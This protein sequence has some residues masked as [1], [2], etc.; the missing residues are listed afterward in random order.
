MPP[1][2]GAV[3]KF[4]GVSI[5]DNLNLTRSG[6]DQNV[7]P[8][9][10]ATWAAWGQAQSDRLK[11]WGF[12]AAGMYSY[13]Y[14]DN[15]PSDGV[16]SEVTFQVSGQAARDDGTFYHCKSVNYNYGT[17]ACGSNFYMPSGGGSTDV[18]DVSCDNGGGYAGAVMSDLGSSGASSIYCPNCGLPAFSAM[19]LV[20]T[21]EAD[22]LYG[23][24]SLGHEDLG[25]IVAAH[26]PMMTASPS[27]YIYPNA[28]LDAKIALR[29]WLAYTYGC[30]NPAGGI[31]T[32]V[33]SGD[34]IY[35]STAYCGSTNAA[36][37]LTALNA[38]WGTSYT[39]W[40]TSDVN[41]EAGIKTGIYKSYGTGSGIL[42][43]SGPHILASSYE[44]SC[45]ITSVSNWTTEPQIETDL[46][47]FV[48]Y[49]AQTYGQKLSA[50]WAQSSANPHP[51]IFVP[52]YDAP[53][54]VYKAIA[55]YFD[56][57]WVSPMAGVASA[58]AAQI[59]SDLQRIIAASSVPG[60]KS[61]PIIVADYAAANPDS[62]FPTG[63]GGAPQYTTQAARGN[64]MVSIWQN[65]IHLQDA[66]SKYVVVGLEHWAFYDQANEGW[67]AGLVTSDHDNPYDGSAD[68]ANGEPGNYG[69]MI[70]P[71]SDFLNAGIC[72]P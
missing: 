6:Q 12:N 48:A 35:S 69:D 55:P 19:Q 32:P 30:T 13:A 27:G 28:T 4:A 5:V 44:S 39:T 56:G 10:Y 37:A 22:N 31:G 51:P 38:A 59:A 2:G 33:S 45:N 9:K 67:N 24:N 17:M 47:N 53:S 43:E 40:S 11:S 18:F 58:T 34:D 71:L 50:A 26:N 15:M 23:F 46:H 66:N 63:T 52:L 36:N 3:C 29:D 20:T 14:D 42:D 65:T 54:Y 64:G 41:G 8:N 7:V 1:G 70:T 49:F 21:E 16:P 62:P 68:I 57:F 25:Y 72:D 60:G 61:M